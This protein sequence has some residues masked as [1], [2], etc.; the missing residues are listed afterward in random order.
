[1]VKSGFDFKEFSR[2]DLEVSK[3]R[4]VAARVVSELLLRLWGGQRGGKGGASVF[5][6]IPHIHSKRS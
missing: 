1:M 6:R 3:T 5:D 4:K 2:V